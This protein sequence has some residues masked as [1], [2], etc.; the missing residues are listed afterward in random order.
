MTGSPLAS[1]LDPML[2]PVLGYHIY[3]QIKVLQKQPCNT[4]K[5]GQTD[6][7]FAKGRELLIGLEMKRELSCI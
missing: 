7:L 6:L 2:V 1:E 5:R 4:F 3:N